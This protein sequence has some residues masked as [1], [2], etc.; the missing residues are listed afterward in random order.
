MASSKVI[1]PS[2]G[3]RQGRPLSTPDARP[4]P[5]RTQSELADAVES[6]GNTN[7]NHYRAKSQHLTTSG[8]VR[9]NLRREAHDRSVR[10]GLRVRAERRQPEAEV[11][12]AVEENSEDAG[13]SSQN[14]HT[15]GFTSLTPPITPQKEETGSIEIHI[16]LISRF[17]R[18]LFCHPRSKRYRQN[19]QG[20]STETHVND[21]EDTN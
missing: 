11:L 6:G 3:L 15:E 12:S 21:E 9:L 18:E 17:H 14:D 7:V 19:F 4:L 10:S 8:N 5:L 16:F 13:F 1:A 2:R 20:E